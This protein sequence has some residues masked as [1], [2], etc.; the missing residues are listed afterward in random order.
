M[1]AASASQR[2]C[3]R[4]TTLGNVRDTPCSVAPGIISHHSCV[5]V[6]RLSPTALFFA[7]RRGG[8]EGKVRRLC[9]SAPLRETHDTG[10]RE[11]KRGHSIFGAVGT[12][13]ELFALILFRRCQ[14][15]L[16]DAHVSEIGRRRLTTPKCNRKTPC[17][18]A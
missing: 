11:A 3:A 8:A 6:S 17:G 13:D 12:S 14:V 10:K 15:H 2:L 7:Q 5:S 9:V 1:C 4:P 18:A 16:G